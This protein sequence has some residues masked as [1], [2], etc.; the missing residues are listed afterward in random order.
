MLWRTACEEMQKAEKLQMELTGKHGDQ[1]S[2]IEEAELLSPLL[3]Q[4]FIGF[5]KTL[6]DKILVVQGMRQKIASGQAHGFQDAKQAWAELGRG[7][8][9]LGHGRRSGG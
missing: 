2:L 3:P 4:P 9:R 7:R 6:A 1:L 8:G 5:H